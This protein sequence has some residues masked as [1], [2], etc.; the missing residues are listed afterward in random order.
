MSFAQNLEIA[1]KFA[2]KGCSV[3]VLPPTHPVPLCGFDENP[4]LQTDPASPDDIMAATPECPLALATGLGVDVLAAEYDY[5]G[6][7]TLDDVWHLVSDHVAETES[8][9]G[10]HH[11]YV[12]ASGAGNF[13]G[14]GI[15][16]LGQGGLVYL[17]SSPSSDR[18]DRYLTWSMSPADADPFPIGDA[19]LRDGLI[20][21]YA[22]ED[23]PRDF[24]LP[25]TDGDREDRRPIG[26][27]TLGKIIKGS[28]GENADKGTLVDL[29]TSARRGGRILNNPLHPQRL[30]V[31]A[32]LIDVANIWGLVE[33]HGLDECLRGIRIGL[34]LGFGGDYFKAELMKGLLRRMAIAPL[35][36]YDEFVADMDEMRR[37]VPN[38]D[39]S[40]DG[41]VDAGSAADVA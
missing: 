1:A 25:R 38:R 4:H 6:E 17:P 26:P 28:G 22:A 11:I 13:R 35:S 37:A 5:G 16:Y 12:P 30:E 7:E 29:I 9:V 24:V 2:A 36:P 15:T 20:S 41:E 33:S 40:A 27:W 3:Y 14:G 19:R 23:L 32:L 18:F 39:A 10:P 34:N 8:N 31:V 21:G